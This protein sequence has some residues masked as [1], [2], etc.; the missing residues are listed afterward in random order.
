VVLSTARDCWD[1][2]TGCFPPPSERRGRQGIGPGKQ[3]LFSLHREDSMDGYYS[4]VSL[5]SPFVSSY[6]GKELSFF[7]HFFL[8]ES[9]EVGWEA[10]RRE[11][12]RLLFKYFLSRTSWKPQKLNIKHIYSSLILLC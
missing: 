10:P 8:S 6:P 4:P 5:C 7:L 3:T 11:S 2:R 12:N 1:M 9:A